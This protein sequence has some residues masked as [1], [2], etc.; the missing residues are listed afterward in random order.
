MITIRINDQ[1]WILG[2]GLGIG[3]RVWGIGIGV[4]GMG[5]G[6]RVW[7]LRLGMGIEIEIWIEDW[8]MAIMIGD[9]GLGLGS[10]IGYWDWN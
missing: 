7:G 10:K 4:L 3:Y 9:W 5:N 6:I 8:E 1:D 2:M